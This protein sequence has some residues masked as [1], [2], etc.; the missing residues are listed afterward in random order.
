MEDIRVT[1][2][3]LAKRIVQLE[4]DIRTNKSTFGDLQAM[5]EE[6]QESYKEYHALIVVAAVTRKP[7]D[8]KALPPFA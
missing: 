6:L 1:Q 3:R 2:R 8:F 5:K 4:L 7:G